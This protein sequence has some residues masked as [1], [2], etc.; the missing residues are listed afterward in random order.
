ML[1]WG[2]SHSY[3]FKGQSLTSPGTMSSVILAQLWHRNITIFTHCTIPAQQHVRVWLN[4]VCLNVTLSS[5][6]TCILL[7]S[8]Q[9]KQK[10]T[11]IIFI[12]LPAE[13]AR[14][15]SPWT[16]LCSLFETKWRGVMFPAVHRD[17]GAFHT[18]ECTQTSTLPGTTKM[19]GKTRS[20]R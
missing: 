10:Q 14:W 12:I 7:W 13:S 8:Q 5:T 4:F 11:C 20:Y 9:R 16:F 19:W 3:S 15:Q 6:S 2:S 1:N 18:C 17:T